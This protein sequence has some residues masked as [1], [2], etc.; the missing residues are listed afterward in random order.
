MASPLEI[1]MALHFWTSPTKYAEHEPDHR[2]S[3]AV[4]AILAW[5]VRDGLLEPTAP[6]DYGEIYKATEALGVW[7]EALCAVPF[8][9]QKWVIPPVSLQQ[10]APK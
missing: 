5:Y 4:K 9:V 1:Q 10:Q 2:T 3:G 7:V 6:N 8:P